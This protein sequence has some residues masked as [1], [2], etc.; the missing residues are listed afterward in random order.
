MSDALTEEQVA[1]NDEVV[2]LAKYAKP[3]GDPPL[4][5]VLRDDLGLYGVRAG[6][7]IGECGACTVLADGQPIRSCR[8]PLS[9]VAGKQIT[10]PEGLGTPDRPHPVQQAFLEEQAAQCGYCVNGMI[11]S[12]AGMLERDAQPDEAAIQD[13]LAGHICRCGAQHRM[14]RAVRRL[15]GHD[16]PACASV[17][18]LPRSGNASEPEET[19]AEPPGALTAAP[20]VEQ[21]LRPLE[22]GGV[23][24]FSGRVELGQGVRT[25]L[26]QVVAAEL[27]LPIEQVVVRSAATDATPDEGYTAGSASLEQGGAALARAAAAYRRLRDAGVQPPTGPI[28]PDDLPRWQGTPLGQPV[29]RTDL[30]AKLTGAPAYLHDV[31]LED[32]AHARALL[33]PTYDARPSRLDVEAARALPGVLAVVH[34]GGVIVVVA[35]RQDQADRAVERLAATA[36][37]DDPGLQTTAGEQRVEPVVDEPGVHEG[38]TSGQRVRASYAKPHEAHASIAP[39]AAVAWSEPDELTVWTHNQGVYP[40]RRELASML[41]VEESTLRVRHVDGPGCYGH[42]GA[43]D[44]AG[45]AALAAQAVPGRP[46]RFAFSVADEF[47]WEPYGP[48]MR[49]DLEAALDP[50]GQ[51]TGWRYHVRTDAHTSR[52]RGAGDRLVA[53]WLRADGPERP[54]AGGGGGVRNAV[55]LYDLPAREING[56]YVRGPL[57]TSAL[58]TLGAYLNVFAIESFMDELAEAAGADPL[59]FRLA[60]IGDE[61]ARAVLETAA[62]VAGWR[63]R[64]GPSGNG[65][66]LAVVRY[67]NSAAYVAQVV[68]VTVEPSTATVS[69]ERVVTVCDAGVVVNPDGLRNQ[70]EGGVLQGLSRAIHEEVRYGTDGVESRDWT[71]YPVLR[72]SEVPRLETVLLDRP[73]YPPL[74]VGEAA[75]PVTPAA[76]ANAVDDRVGIR[77]RELPLTPARFRSR[78]EQMDD[79][80]EVFRVLT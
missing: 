25:A 40:L 26:A 64:V 66:G 1:V 28:Q 56:T 75:T 27:D 55:P 63:P 33:P 22:D 52:P 29:A 74:G 59:A 16:Q 3:D 30:V 36:R 48:A 31:A 6:C 77:M 37:W 79:P 17:R 24:V 69:V 71:T 19:R 5:Q 43:D 78:L 15:A 21:W 2:D 7:A 61:R 70:L 51:I 46:V 9:A 58:R 14:L 76:L 8:T 32:M 10:T 35:E 73:G 47:G 53:S 72:F 38:L 67:K 11:M 49:A 54:W 45:F 60:R 44:A 12:V 68:E 39:S 20:L 50:D 57:R 18:Q 80:A 13:T 4:T 23:E 42:N 41:G 65:Q 34:D 62:E